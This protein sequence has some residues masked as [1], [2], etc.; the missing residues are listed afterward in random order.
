MFYSV[1]RPAF[2]IKIQD[3]SF[4]AEKFDIVSGFPIVQ[5]PKLSPQSNV[6]HVVVVR[7]KAAG[8][9][10]LTHATVSYV[11]NERTRRVQLGHTSELG[12]AY[13][14]KL[15]DYNRRFASHMVSNSN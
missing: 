4:T 7:P 15:K 10:N 12:E 14:Q 2:D 3:D 13:I 11:A 5:W 8:L 9:F 1:F 6:S